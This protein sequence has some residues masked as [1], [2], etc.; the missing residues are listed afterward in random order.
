MQPNEFETQMKILTAS[1]MRSPLSK[2]SLEILY[3]K[4][5]ACDA[6]IFAVAV[7]LLSRG[8]YMPKFGQIYAAYDQAKLSLHKAKPEFQGCKFCD[9]GKVPYTQHKENFMGPIAY[10]GWCR[11]CNPPFKKEGMHG[12]FS[13]RNYPGIKF[14]CGPANELFEGMIVAKNAAEIVKSFI[15]K[16]DPEKEAKRKENISK[17]E[18]G[19]LPF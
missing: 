7:D 4:F 5:S 1:F 2:D 9:K 14:Q 19:E 13:D 16:E 10:L 3:K 15:G 12:L 11:H 8:E 6:E 17:Y 18:T